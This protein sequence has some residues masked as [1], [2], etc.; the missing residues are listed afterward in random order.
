MNKRA[1]IRSSTTAGLGLL[2]GDQLWA[3]YSAMPAAELANEPDF[4]ETLRGQYRL[5]PAYINLENG[6]YSMQSQPVL[7][8]FVAKVRDVNFLASRYMRTTQVPDKLAARARLAAV[9]GCAPEEL[10]ITRNTT[11]SLDTVIAGF[12]WKPGDEAIMAEQDYGAMR[13]MFALQAKRYGMVP[14]N[15]S[16]PMDPKS[17]DEI[18]QLYASA[19]TPRTRLLMICHMVN[20]TGHILPVKKVAA[21]AHAK[22]VDVMVDGA[23]AFA[24]LDFRIPDLDVDYYGASLHKWLGAPLGTGLLYVRREKV[25]KLWPVF[26]DAGMKDDDIRKLNHTGTHPVHT[27][28]AI[29]NAIAF[30]ESV[31]IQRKEARL[32]FLQNYWTRKV[33]DVPNVMMFTPSDPQRSCAI[34]NVGVKGMKPSELAKTL[35]DKYKIWTVAIDSAGVHG[36]RVTPQ[37]FIRTS[38]LDSFVTAI[39]EIAKG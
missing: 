34:A 11:E 38:E 21:M 20:I 4:W 5:N 31:G 26:A 29:E 35:L 24:Q 8:A 19:I 2:F 27:D 9:A 30:H 37:L 33:R 25:A 10:I 12:D 16:L 17:D 1:F 28:L 6:Y 23:H 7:D 14:V 22:G 32:R 15:L 36:V 13:D 18:V 39:R 3:K